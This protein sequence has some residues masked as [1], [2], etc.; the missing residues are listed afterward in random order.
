VVSRPLVGTAG[1]NLAGRW[2][3]ARHCGRFHLVPLVSSESPLVAQAAHSRERVPADGHGLAFVLLVSTWAECSPTG[4]RQARSDCP[5]S[6]E[7]GKVRRGDPDGIGHPDVGKFP[8]LAQGVDRGGGHRQPL[9]C[10]PNGQEPAR[11]VL[12]RSEPAGGQSRARGHSGDKRLGIPC[13]RLGRLDR[14]GRH[15]GKESAGL[16]SAGKV[17]TI[18]G[19]ASGA[20]GH[21]F[22]SSIACWVNGR[23]SLVEMRWVPGPSVAGIRV[24]QQ[25]AANGLESALAVAFRGASADLRPARS[26]HWFSG[27]DCQSALL[28]PA[29]P[30]L[31]QL[32]GPSDADPRRTARWGSA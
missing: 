23:E 17:W 18:P 5:P 27:W 21:W 30:A 29:T 26:V 31:P 20:E 24:V 28:P 9:R 10:L 19:P 12:Q 25:G 1:G 32:A 8:A 2:E 7:R 6:Q 15:S 4:L 13:E 3:S 11:V 14:R 22:E 16:R